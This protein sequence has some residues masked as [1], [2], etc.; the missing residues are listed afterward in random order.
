MVEPLLIN[1]GEVHQSWVSFLLLEPVLCHQQ[2]SNS[3]QHLPKTHPMKCHLSHCSQQ[4]SDE[5]K[6]WPPNFKHV[7]QRCIIVGLAVGY[8]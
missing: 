3:E 2:I 8:L 7:M 6:P 5:T 1:H 4:H